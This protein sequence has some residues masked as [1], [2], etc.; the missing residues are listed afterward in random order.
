MMEVILNSSSL[1]EVK[2]QLSETESDQFV[3]IP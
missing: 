1:A 2:T 3:E